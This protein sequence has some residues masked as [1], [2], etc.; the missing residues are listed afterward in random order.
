M[1]LQKKVGVDKVDAARDFLFAFISF[2]VYNFVVSKK[3]EEVYGL[4]EEADIEV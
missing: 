1:E 3:V 4:E 2:S